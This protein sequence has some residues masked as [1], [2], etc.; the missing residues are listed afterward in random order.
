MKTCDF[1][2]LALYLSLKLSLNMEV[3]LLSSI[4]KNL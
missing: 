3:Q 2:L 1:Y 4:L